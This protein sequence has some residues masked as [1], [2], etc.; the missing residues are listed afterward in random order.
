MPALPERPKLS[1]PL[2]PRRA[3]PELHVRVTPALL[4][5]IDKLIGSRF[6]D[7]AEAVRSLLYVALRCPP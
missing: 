5:E 1:P 2:S 3:H 6:L 7:R 4:E